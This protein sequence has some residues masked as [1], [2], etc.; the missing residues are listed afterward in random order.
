MHRLLQLPRGKQRAMRPLKT[1]IKT[2]SAARPALWIGLPMSLVVGVGFY[3]ATAASIESDSR[4]RFAEHAESASKTI[5]G[6]IKSYTDVLRGTLSLF[7]ISDPLTRRQFHGYV[8]GLGLQEH[9]PAIE[10][11]N[12]AYH[13]RDE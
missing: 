7:Q 8:Q 3:L 13:L 1:T 12:F 9:F 2:F 11:I 6:R 10:S 5:S 4:N